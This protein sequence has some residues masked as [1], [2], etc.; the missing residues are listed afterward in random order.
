MIA[1]T[2]C[3]MY[4]YQIGEHPISVHKIKKNHDH[5]KRGGKIIS[6]FH[7]PGV[8]S[9]VKFPRDV[10]FWLAVDFVY[11]TLIPDGVRQS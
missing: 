8:E 5:E 7:I 6:I 3:V 9:P 1:S 4:N 10:T 2:I 11:E